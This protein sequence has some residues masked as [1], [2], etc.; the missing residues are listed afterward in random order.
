MKG[1]S[2]FTLLELLVTVSLMALVAGATMAVLGGVFHV[3]DRAQNRGMFEQELQISFEAI[4]RDLHNARPF[5]LIPFK[6]SYDTFSFPILM[7]TVWEDGSSVREVG[8]QAFFFDGYKRQLCR[9]KHSYRGL[10]ARSVKQGGRSVLSGI[11]RLR[12]AYYVLDPSTLSYAWRDSCE[13]EEPPLAVKIDVGYHVASNEKFA[14]KT[15]IVHLP[16]A[17]IR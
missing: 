4:Q 16:T 17:P 15:F 6:G 10:K 13:S 3:W 7:E 11:D 9:T 12:F 2:G 5:R 8:R 1:R 14:R